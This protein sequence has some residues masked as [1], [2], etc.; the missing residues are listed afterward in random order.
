MEN[1][2]EPSRS[3]QEGTGLQ[4]L[5]RL[6]RLARD[7]RG[8][9]APQ[10]GACLL[11]GPGVPVPPR[12]GQAPV[13]CV[14]S[15][16]RE[17]AKEP[18]ASFGDGARRRQQ[19][20]PWRRVTS[21]QDPWWGRSAPT[22]WGRGNPGTGPT[23]GPRGRGQ[24]AGTGR[25]MYRVEIQRQIRR[26]DPDEGRDSN[27]AEE[28]RVRIQGHLRGAVPI[29]I[30][31]ERGWRTSREEEECWGP[32]QLYSMV[33]HDRGEDGE[34]ED[35]DSERRNLRRRRTPVPGETRRVGRGRFWRPGFSAQPRRV[36][37]ER[38]GP[39]EID[40]ERESS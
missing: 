12:G 25:G 26:R 40:M 37:M 30:P 35:S 9:S 34:D 28:F 4:D 36:Q 18:R 5:I 24:D 14:S 13:G 22:P 8:R 10:E 29:P 6:A 38:G 16:V 2:P 39:P 7:G 33:P 27:H 11:E 3:P 31:V 20:E 23:P 19:S 17:E 21:A 1:I 15:Q 32:P